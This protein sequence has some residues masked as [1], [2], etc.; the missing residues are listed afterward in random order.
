M[1]Y[2]IAYILILL[3]GL[4]LGAAALVWVSRRPPSFTVR[5][6]QNITLSL[7]TLFFTL[8]A[9]EVFFKV[10]FAQSDAWNQTLA[11]QNWFKRYWVTNSLGYRDLEWDPA[12]VRARK[13]ILVL[14]DSFAAGQGVE[15]VEDRFSNRLNARLGSDYVVMN[16]ATPGISTQEEI[17]RVMGFPYKPDILIFQYFINDI[18]H[19]AH[20]EGLI[21]QAPRIEPGPWLK[22]LVDNS[23]AANFIYWRA[24]RLLPLPWQ[25]DDYSW[26]RDAYN[27]PKI[28]WLHQQELLTIYNGAASEHVKLLVVVF[29]GLTDVARSRE[30]T[31]KVVD[32]FR[33][34][35]TPVLDVSDLVEGVPVK[36]RVAN[37]LDAHPSEWV[38]QVV[39]DRLYEMVLELEQEPGR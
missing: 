30:V 19:A 3:A 16:I 11:S 17:D 5:L 24:V 22:P 27:N 21:S 1:G 38:H 34:R 4:A 2:W 36:Q 23:Y 13:K 28:W 9:A 15:R 7:L 14:G 39:A 35:G 18:R 29:P 8:M 31:S 12:E 26:L 37:S 25:A 20:S 33:E 10:F 32:F 6:V